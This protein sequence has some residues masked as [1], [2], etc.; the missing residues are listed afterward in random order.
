MMKF[1]IYGKITNVPNHQPD[2]VLQQLQ[3]LRVPTFVPK[4]LDDVMRLHL[5]R[6][7]VAGQKDTMVLAL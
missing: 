1:H 6:V 3:N 4:E 7:T 5:I 2:E